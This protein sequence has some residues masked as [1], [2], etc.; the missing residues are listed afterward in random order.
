MKPSPLVSVISTCY[1]QEPFLD[2]YF[3]S[4]LNQTYQNIQLILID[5]GSRDNS[6]SNIQ[7]RKEQLIRRF[8]D[9]Y[10][11]RTENQGFLKALAHGLRQSRGD[12]VCFLE[13]DD[14]YFPTKIEENV[15]YLEAHPEF[16]AVH[17]DFNR[18]VGSTLSPDCYKSLGFR[19]PTGS[20]YEA[21]LLCP[22]VQTLTFCGRGNL[23]R[24]TVDF[25]RYYQ[26]GYLRGD[27]PMWLDL[28]LRAQF[29][30]LDKS[31]GCYR[32]LAESASHSQDPVKRMA[33]LESSY[34]IKLDFIEDHGAPEKIRE[35]ILKEYFWDLFKFGY[36][37]GLK[38]PCRRGLQWLTERY[39]EQYGRWQYKLRGAVIGNPVLWKA[40]SH[41]D[42]N[43][44]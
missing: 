39:P 6:W 42:A 18:L 17:S 40:L 33:F 38:E 12:Y 35:Q 20:V 7:S 10:L 30:Y 13:A 26:K 29:G 37:W 31:L 43:R 36:R 24:E 14:Y 3:N 16:G 22:A 23:V 44:M 4:L 15:A 32:I 28:S 9:L 1:N 8:P 25:E 2:D 19:P 41:L 21:F 11:Q 5:D 34:R 27:S